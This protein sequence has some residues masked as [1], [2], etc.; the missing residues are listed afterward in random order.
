MRIHFNGFEVV[1]D[2][3]VNEVP[4]DVFVNLGFG[5]HVKFSEIVLV[6]GREGHLGEEL[7]IFDRSVIKPEK[8]LVVVES[9]L[10]LGI[11]EVSISDV[12]VTWC[13]IINIILL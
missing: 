5:E 3:E 1:N 12:F 9:L 6:V 11:F 10:V 13:Q 2:A 8:F 4:L 7:F